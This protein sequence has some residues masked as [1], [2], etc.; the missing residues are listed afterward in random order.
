M[1][2]AVEQ[3]IW[4]LRFSEALWRL[5]FHLG[6]TPMTKRPNAKEIRGP[7][8][9][10]EIPRAARNDRRRKGM[11]ERNLTADERRWTRIRIRLLSLAAC[12][13]ELSQFSVQFSALQQSAS[14]RVHLRLKLFGS[15][16]PDSDD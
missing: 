6:K 9:Q 15:F 16:F 8:R 4:P 13:L 14:I 11:T 7:K 10:S 3:T 2:R 12:Y 1:S 5:E